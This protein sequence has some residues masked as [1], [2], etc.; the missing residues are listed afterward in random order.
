[1]PDGFEMKQWWV[2]LL[3]DESSTS[4]YMRPCMH[5]WESKNAVWLSEIRYKFWHNIF[6]SVDIKEIHLPKTYAY[7]TYTDMHAH[8]VVTKRLNGL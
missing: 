6:P 7:R 3:V 2:W 8:T 4:Q 5:E 1:M